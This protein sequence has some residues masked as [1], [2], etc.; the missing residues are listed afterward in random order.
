MENRTTYIDASLLVSP[1]SFL[2]DERVREFQRKLYIRAKQDKNLK[3][4]V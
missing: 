3:L 1:S 4:I 2:T